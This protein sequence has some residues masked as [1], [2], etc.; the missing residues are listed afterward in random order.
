MPKNSKC[1][2]HG[3][4]IPQHLKTSA[5][6]PRSPF[7]PILFQKY[8]LIFGKIRL[9][10]NFSKYL[11][12]DTKKGHLANLKSGRGSARINLFFVFKKAQ[13]P[14]KFFFKFL[15]SVFLESDILEELKKKKKRK[16]ESNVVTLLY[17]SSGT[18]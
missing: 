7:R 4:N 6:K 12:I 10:P 2:L 13:K 15:F 1:K 9:L 18:I 11:K 14:I 8:N 16:S 3:L 17:L 5:L